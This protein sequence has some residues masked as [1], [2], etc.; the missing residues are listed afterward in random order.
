MSVATS[1]SRHSAELTSAAARAAEQ[2][3]GRLEEQ[4]YAGWDPYDALSSPVLRTFGRTPLLRRIAIQ[5]LKRAPVNVRPLL[6]VR[7]LRHTKALALLASAYARLGDGDR[8][9]RLRDLLLERELPGG[10]WGYDFDVQTRWGY[11][12]AGTA[13]AVVTTFATHAL[14]DT[15]A[16]EENE[17][18]AGAVERALGFARRDLHVHAGSDAFFAYFAGGRTPIHNANLLVASLFARAGGSDGRD[19]A[20]AA[21][22]FTVHR[23][24][25][26]GTWPYGEQRGLEWVDGFH[27]AYVLERLAEWHDVEPD[28]AIEGAL[29][30]G[31]AVYL[32]RLFDA[33]GAPRATIDGAYPR[34]IHAAASAVTALLAL[35]EFDSGAHAAAERVL[36]W[37]LANMRRRDGRYAFQLHRRLMNKTAYVRW[38]D[39]HMMLALATY[40][41]KAERE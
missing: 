9:V 16:F 21:V 5:T 14:L 11:Y 33:D 30:R 24:R 10:G 34:D 29:E 6:G 35:E 2:L 22:L 8:A 19:F 32:E 31:T 7:Q 1:A 20:R 41:S 15:L 18:A 26:D 38:N 37:T 3:S 17:G 25:A 4:H 12:R 23:Q 40:L 27:T 36:R 13:N 28:P 39:A